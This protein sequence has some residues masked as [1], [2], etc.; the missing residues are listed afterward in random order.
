MT[1][2]ERINAYYQSFNEND[3]LTSSASGQMEYTMTMKRL[4]KH[5]P[6]QAS[7]LDLGGAAGT[8]TFPLADL[9]YRIHLAD[10]SPRLIAQAK[11]KLRACPNP[12]VISCNV[13][14]AL[15]LS[16]YEDASFDVVLL[17]G[18]LYHLLEA[19]ERNQCI[20]EVSRVLKRGGLVIAAFIPRMSGSIAIIDR[21]FFAP[22]QVDGHNL[23]AVFRTGKFHN[24][25]SS[26]FQEGYY[27]TCDEI[28][29]IFTANGFSKISLCSVR[30]ITYGK[31]AS[32]LQMTDTDMQ[33]VVLR[34]AEETC[35]EKSIVET[36]GHALYIGIR[37]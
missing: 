32:I 28:E 11:E 2:F 15:D 6:K 25:A 31:E 13:V 33:Q 24:N 4:L 20:R 22:G 16:V 3:R 1:D 34:L 10:L 18:P 21:Y 26:G 9:G 37:L 27:P 23:Q 12:N 14:N 7:I 35:E 8:Y 19:H 29:S 5:L 36:C 30:G 17:M